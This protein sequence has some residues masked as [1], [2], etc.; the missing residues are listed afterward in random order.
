MRKRQLVKDMEYLQKEIEEYQSRLDETTKTVKPQACTDED[1]RIRKYLHSLARVPK[2][3]DPDV[4]HNPK[5]PTPGTKLISRVDEGKVV[6]P[7]CSISG[8]HYVATN[9]S[10]LFGNSIAVFKDFKKAKMLKLHYTFIFGKSIS[11]SVG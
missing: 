3:Q 2:F 4:C 7:R 1:I 8:D 10:L 6:C 11:D 9:A 5:C